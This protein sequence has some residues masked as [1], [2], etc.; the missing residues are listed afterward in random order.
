MEQEPQCSLGQ[1]K[2]YPGTKVAEGLAAKEYFQWT[3]WEAHGARHPCWTKSPRCWLQSSGTPQLPSEVQ[4]LPSPAW[5]VFPAS[6]C[7]FRP[8]RLRGVSVFRKGMEQI[9]TNH[10]ALL[11]L[12]LR[13]FWSFWGICS[14]LRRLLSLL[15][16]KLGSFLSYELRLTF[17]SPLGLR[18]APKLLG[19]AGA[20]CQASRRIR[21]AVLGLVV[22]GSTSSLK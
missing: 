10:I 11:P 20:A 1:L 12:C 4:Q 6:S 8:Q 15:P 2:Q 17:E 16:G 19:R 3:A 5:D 9:L 21:D 22:A 13:S 14:F 18:M 7:S